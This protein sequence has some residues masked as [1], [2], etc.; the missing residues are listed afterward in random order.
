MKRLVSGLT[1]AA[2][3]AMGCESLPHLWERPKPAPAPASAKPAAPPV[4]NAEQ[5]NDANARQIAEALLDEMD[6]DA[7]GEPPPAGE[8]VQNLRLDKHP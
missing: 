1:L 3:L 7:Q 4:V 2:V 5:I 6:R 8:R